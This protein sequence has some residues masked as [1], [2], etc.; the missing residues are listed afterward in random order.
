MANTEQTQ[1][2]QSARA[3]RAAAKAAATQQADK[4]A[5]LKKAEVLAAQKDK[6]KKPAAPKPRRVAREEA[7][8]AAEAQAEQDAH[9]KVVDTEVSLVK[10]STPS[11]HDL[12]RMAKRANREIRDT[13]RDAANAAGKA[14][15]D[16]LRGKQPGTTADALVRR[17][18]TVGK[19]QASLVQAAAAAARQQERDA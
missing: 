9:L 15:F 7:R 13:A 10:G 2:R 6:P 18:R 8:K 5:T 16:V 1:K 3:R 11:L 4:D 19:A 14:A 12:N 17:H